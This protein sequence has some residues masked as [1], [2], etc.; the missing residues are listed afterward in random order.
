VGDEGL[1]WNT[2]ESEIL[3]W[4]KIFTTINITGF[5]EKMPN[6]A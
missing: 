6:W 2:W 3:R 1:D 5:P 4:K